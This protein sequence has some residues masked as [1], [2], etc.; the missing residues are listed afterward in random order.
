MEM[1]GN[2]SKNNRNDNTLKCNFI[3]KLH[4]YKNIY[5][6]VMNIIKIIQIK[7]DKLLAY[8]NQKCYHIYVKPT[9]ALVQ[10]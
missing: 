8:P 9:R 1:E 6:N 4:N 2:V 5:I 3:I 10:Y 7:R